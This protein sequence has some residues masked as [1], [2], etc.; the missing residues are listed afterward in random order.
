MNRTC[1]RGL[2]PAHHCGGLRQAAGRSELP[3][4]QAEA[5]P[6]SCDWRSS[7]RTA[8][9]LNWTSRHHSTLRRCATPSKR[10]P[11]CPSCPQHLIKPLGCGVVTDL[12]SPTAS[13]P[14]PSSLRPVT[15][16]QP[17][18]DAFSAQPHP[19]PFVVGLVTLR[20]LGGLLLCPLYGKE[21]REVPHLCPSA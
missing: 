19:S 12:P 6:P 21:K 11:T 15:S 5:R 9:P 17:L 2:H 14:S 3:S 20:S 16:S 18:E 8:R 13:H 4:P 10:L 1:C 7:I